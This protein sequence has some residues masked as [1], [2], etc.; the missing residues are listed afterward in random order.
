MPTEQNFNEHFI[1]WWPRNIGS[2]TTPVACCSRKIE[3]GDK[4]RWSFSRIAGRHGTGNTAVCK[5]SAPSIPSFLVSRSFSSRRAARKMDRND[6]TVRRFLSWLNATLSLLSLSLSLC[7]FFF[8]RVLLR[9]FPFPFESNDDDV[10]LA[11]RCRS[12]LADTALSAVLSGFRVGSL[13]VTPDKIARARPLL[14]SIFGQPPRFF[15]R[16]RKQVRLPISLM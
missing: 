5:R 14:G 7:F 2:S 10:P 11:S 3:K 8:H 4:S 9:I 1:S 15:Q 13:N 6:L 16:E 12:Y